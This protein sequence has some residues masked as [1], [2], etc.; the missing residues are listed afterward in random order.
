MASARILGLRTS[1]EGDLQRVIIDLD[2]AIDFK[3]YAIPE[4]RMVYVSLRNA[5][6]DRAMNTEP[7]QVSSGYLTGIRMGQY[8]PKIAR[9][10]LDGVESSKVSVAAERNPDR[11]V[12][13][14]KGGT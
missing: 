12:I 11:I 13:T 6:F 2:T 8:K 4:Q 1:T 14:V 10:V 5:R 7:V 9:V 3:K